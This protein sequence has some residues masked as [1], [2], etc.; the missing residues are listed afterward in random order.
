MFN[1]LKSKIIAI[2]VALFLLG[3]FCTF[4]RFLLGGFYTFLRFYTNIFA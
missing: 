1:N 3:G 4:L 2:C